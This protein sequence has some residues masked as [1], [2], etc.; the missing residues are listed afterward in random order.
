M[1]MWRASFSLALIVAL[2]GG[3][4]IPAFADPVQ[5][6]QTLNGGG[7]STWEVNP[8]GGTNNGTPTGTQ[9][10][11]CGL[12]VNNVSLGMLNDAYD[13]GL[14]VWIDDV[15]V[16][17]P[18]CP[19]TADADRTGETV[20]VGPVT[21]SGL[22]VSV[23]YAAMPS[24]PTL[25]TLVTLNNTGGAPVDITMKWV[26]NL[27]SDNLTV[28]RGTSSGST[29][30]EIADRWI[31]TSDDNLGTDVVNGFALFGP[32]TPAV[33]PSAV[34]MVGPNDGGDTNSIVVSYPVTVPAGETRYLLFYNQVSA[35][36]EAALSSITTF[37]TNPTGE[38]VAGLDQTV[39]DRVVN[40][41]LG[42]V[43]PPPTL[44]T[45]F[46][47]DGDGKADLGVYRPGTAEWLIFGSA[48]GFAGPVPLGGPGLGDVPVPQDYDGDGKTDL[49]VYRTTTA[50]WFI[51][52]SATGFNGAVP[53]G[54]PGLGDT[55]VAADYDGDGKADLAVYRP[56]TAEW[57]IFGS[58]T[59]FPGPVLLGGP[60]LGDEP[61]PADYDGDGKTDLA[62]YRTTTGEWFIFGSTTGF[63]GSVLLGSPALGDIPLEGR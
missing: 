29:T 40:W 33:T 45:R 7:G 9:D 42:A 12:N 63:G 15:I 11:S 50:E 13:F 25:R 57:F 5:L 22:D 35:T 61:V 39:L 6:P 2:A 55:P 54:S 21:M 18:G 49:A 51:F 62:V 43:T 16:V 44:A 48:T 14:E 47:F 38:L 34:S 60:G 20:T 28:V 8:S 41:D 37:D 27:G 24:T 36:N 26:T 30:F 32:G 3:A 19:T 46:D 17:P 4:A 56:G 58:A 31:V 10:N 1:R 59:G 23:A 52:G 53:L